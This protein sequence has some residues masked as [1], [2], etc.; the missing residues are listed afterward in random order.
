MVWGSESWPRR[1]KRKEANGLSLS[2][3][4]NKGWEQALL[5]IPFNR[6]F[7][8]LQTSLSA[9]DCTSH[10]NTFWM[11]SLQS[12]NYG[13]K[14]RLIGLWL[15]TSTNFIDCYIGWQ[16]FN[17]K[18]WGCWRMAFVLARLQ[19]Q[20]SPDFGRS[21]KENLEKFQDLQVDQSGFP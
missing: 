17:V 12:V 4:M 15:G 18:T 1:I 8:I 19:Q 5:P 10:P 14:L 21:C 13:S 11:K 3:Q 7:I 16:R 20:D 9:K 6:A 2:F